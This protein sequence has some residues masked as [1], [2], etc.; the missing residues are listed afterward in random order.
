MQDQPVVLMDEPFSALDAVTRHKLQTL[1]ATLLRGKTVVLITHDP[2]EAIRLAHQLYILQGMPAQ[3]ESL[4]LPASRPP[5]N[6]DAD[7][8]QLQQQIIEALERDYA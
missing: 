6:L 5:R 8:A 1:A 7:G 4:A 3:A 2:L